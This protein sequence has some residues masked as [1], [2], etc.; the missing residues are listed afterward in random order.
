MST[1]I[2]TISPRMVVV[3][4]GLAL[5]KMI[6]SDIRSCTNKPVS[7]KFG[8]VAVHAVRM[9]VAANKRNVLVY[10]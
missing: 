6:R 8:S 5:H 7:I 1:C 10:K 4:R 3:D 2:S 9:G